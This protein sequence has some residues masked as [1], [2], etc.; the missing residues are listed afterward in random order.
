MYRPG[1]VKDVIVRQD[2]SNEL[3]GIATT[4]LPDI[5]NKV[6]TMS[7]LGTGE[8]EH[9]IDTAFNALTL[10]L[11]FQGPG[12]HIGFTKGKAVS[13]IIKGALS[14][15]DDESHDE[16]LQIMTVSVKGRLKKRSGGEFGAAVKNET[17]MEFAL[18]YY[19]LEIDG[20]V[21]IEIDVLN[22]I[23]IIDGEDLGAKLK[24]AL[25]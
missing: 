19:K 2:G 16:A 3:I 20:E 25:S 24:Q 1:I 21:I 6:E 9:V 18:T 7:G 15:V 12:K 23:V 10:G 5:E 11:K 13:L 8:F 4:T 14:G 17:E 22:K